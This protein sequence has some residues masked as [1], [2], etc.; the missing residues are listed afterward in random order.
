MSV[1]FLVNI[2]YSDSFISESHGT[3]G[4]PAQR[5]VSCVNY[6]RGPIEY[7]ESIWRH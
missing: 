6:R 2:V 4:G 7:I 1:T 3:S 5:A